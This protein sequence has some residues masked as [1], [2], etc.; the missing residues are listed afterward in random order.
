MGAAN[1]AGRDD[2]V[3]LLA[4]L[5]EHGVASDTDRVI[6]DGRNYRV[7]RRVKSFRGRWYD[8]MCYVDAERG[9]C[10]TIDLHRL[11]GDGDLIATSRESM[12]RPAV[13]CTAL[14]CWMARVE[15]ETTQ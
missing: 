11:D 2:A 1:Q 14:A 6:Y 7:F 4:Y 8:L 5:V 3:A 15:R 12:M 10:A 13:I 9:G